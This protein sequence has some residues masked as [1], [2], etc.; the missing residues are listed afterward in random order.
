MD[1]WMDG[2][3]MMMMMMM[4]LIVVVCGTIV[5]ALFWKVQKRNLLKF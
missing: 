5:R 2:W 4:M 1:G 3:M